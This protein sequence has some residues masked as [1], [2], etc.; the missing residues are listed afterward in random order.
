L[1]PAITTAKIRVIPE[2]ESISVEDSKTIWV[3]VE[4]GGHVDVTDGTDGGHGMDAV[5]VVDDS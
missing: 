2:V 4:V 1:T 5:I 3:A